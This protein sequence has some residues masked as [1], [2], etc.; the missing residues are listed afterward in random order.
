MEAPT[1]AAQEACWWAIK[2]VPLG[3]KWIWRL[4]T[5]GM[6]IVFF[7]VVGYETLADPKNGCILELG[8]FLATRQKHGW[9]LRIDH[10]TDL[11][12]WY[13]AANPLY[14]L[15]TALR[16]KELVETDAIQ[17]ASRGRGAW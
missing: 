1:L 3:S 6:R 2:Q 9:P 17:R 11:P 7:T 12:A 15:L 16:M 13:I 5:P 4:E 14:N 8:S 10:L